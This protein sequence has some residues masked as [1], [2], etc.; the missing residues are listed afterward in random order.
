MPS[1]L[2][3]RRQRRLAQSRDRWKARAIAKQQEIRRLRV[4]IHDLLLSRDRWKQR[5]RAAVL[6]AAPAPEAYPRPLS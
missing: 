5:C 1:S 2:E 6:T 4:C 3:Q